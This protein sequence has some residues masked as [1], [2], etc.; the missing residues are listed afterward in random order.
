VAAALSIAGVSVGTW[1]KVEVSVSGSAVTY[2][3]SDIAGAVTEQT[4]PPTVV[5]AYDYKKA[6]YYL[7]ADKRIVGLAYKTLGGALGRIVNPN[8]N[9]SG[10]VDHSFG[11]LSADDGIRAGSGVDSPH[12]KCH[13]YGVTNWN[14]T[15]DFFKDVSVAE[16]VIYI[17]HMSAIVYNDAQD[18][19]YDLYYESVTTGTGAHGIAS[20]GANTVRLAIRDGGFFDSADF[21]DVLVMRAY[22]FVWT[23]SIP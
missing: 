12:L 9:H 15:V 21:D 18:R 14:M 17:D 2:A 8:S 4:I 23:E 10:F 19:T 5:A 13:V 7:S 16:D 6:G 22:L 11:M 20:V 3:V 1:C